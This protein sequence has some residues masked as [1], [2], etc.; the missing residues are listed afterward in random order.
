MISSGKSNQAR[1]LVTLAQLLAVIS[2]S[3]V[4]GRFL[5]G[6]LEARS[7][8]ALQSQ[9]VP[10]TL[11][12]RELMHK[13]DGNII[14]LNERVEARRSD[15]VTVTR[16]IPFHE[17]GQEKT[18]I[19]RYVHFPSGLAIVISEKWSIKTSSQGKGLSPTSTV[20]DSA[21]KCIN[22]YA[23]KPFSDGEAIEG[24]EMIAGYKTVRINGGNGVL[25]WLALDHGCVR[26]K[27]RIEW[28]PGKGANETI[29]V[30]LTEGEPES[31]LFDTSNLREVP[32]SERMR[33]LLGDTCPSCLTKQQER[34]Q[35][36]DT[37]YFNNRPK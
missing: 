26:V 17:L 27:D 33:I 13:E 35:K 20:R 2:L 1:L 5:S 15:G 12:V 4:T 8:R 36:A 34:I 18:G 21:S 29:L 9:I 16:R 22:S 32:P 23:G 6:Q 37:F 10:Y 30:S 19:E 7:L 31:S 11:T 14:L 3:V 28:G 24:E 25:R